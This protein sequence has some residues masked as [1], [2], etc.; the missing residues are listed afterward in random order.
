MKILLGKWHWLFSGAMLAVLILLG[1]YLFDAPLGLSD[2]LSA[3]SVYCRETVETQSLDVWP[4]LNWQNGI[5][6]GVF[7]G[8][9]CSAL[10]TGEWRLKIGFDDASGFSGKTWKTAISGVLGGF[11]MMVGCLIAGDIVF[12]MISAAI[13]LSEGAWIFFG[14]MAVSGVVLSILFRRK[15][16]AYH[17]VA[18]AARNT[19]VSGKEVSQ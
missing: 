10:C 2:A 8:A 16:S 12:G 4:E 3:F 1:L 17:E 9:F 5:L 18:S 11:L 15:H 13:Q 7:I 14:G 19:T 6:L